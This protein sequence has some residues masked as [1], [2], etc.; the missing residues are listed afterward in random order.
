VQGK[1]KKTL[2]VMETISNA[3]LLFV[4]Y[5]TSS[6]NSIYPPS[7]HSRPC[8]RYSLPMQVIYSQY[9]SSRRHLVASAIRLPHHPHRQM[10]LPSSSSCS[11]A[12]PPPLASLLYNTP[13]TPYNV[14]SLSE[15]LEAA[16]GSPPSASPC[17]FSRVSQSRMV[18]CLTLH[19]S[20]AATLLIRARSTDCWFRQSGSLHH[21]LRR[22][23]QSRV[24]SRACYSV[25]L[26]ALQQGSRH[27]PS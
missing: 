6:A 7:H 20:L 11:R 24:G 16:S 10:K 26:P 19:H 14:S 4:L 18:A 12:S 22:P 25:E 17:R 13:N 21:N 23:S 3:D 8:R 9:S 1:K 5:C 15:C 2:A 27:H